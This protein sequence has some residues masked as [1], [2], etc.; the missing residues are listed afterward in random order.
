MKAESKEKCEELIARLKW[1][2]AGADWSYK[3]PTTESEEESKIIWDTVQF[4]EGLIEED[5]NEG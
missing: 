5:K 3:A 1:V 4:L 2:I